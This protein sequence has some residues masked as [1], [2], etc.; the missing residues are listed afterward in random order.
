MIRERKSTERMLKPFNLKVCH[1][2]KMKKLREKFDAR[3]GRE[4]DFV[5]NEN[6]GMKREEKLPR[7]V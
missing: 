1:K 3:S 5:D 6:V 4:N 7:K 2:N